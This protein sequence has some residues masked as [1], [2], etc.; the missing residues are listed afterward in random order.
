VQVLEHPN[1]TVKQSQKHN[2]SGKFGGG[3][4]QLNDL[5]LEGIQ[6]NCSSQE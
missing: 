1:I 6:D 3:Y 2:D 5:V 4:T